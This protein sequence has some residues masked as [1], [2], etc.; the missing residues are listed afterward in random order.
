M[1]RAVLVCLLMLSLA[2]CE[3]ATPYPPLASNSAVAGGFTE[4]KLDDTHY[5]VTFKGADVTSRSQVETY[6]LYRAAE[7]AAVQGDDWFEMVGKHANGARHA[8]IDPS[9]GYWRPEWTFFEGPA[10]RGAV[11]RW[12]PSRC[13]AWTATRPAP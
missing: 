11:R 8:W 13:R 9:W 7:L 6:L 10:S 5:R 12:A 3:T 1:Q 2:A 4:Q